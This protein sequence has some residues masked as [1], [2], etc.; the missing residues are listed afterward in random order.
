MP[1][2]T[3]MTHAEAVQIVVEASQDQVRLHARSG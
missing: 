3:E 1:M 2:T